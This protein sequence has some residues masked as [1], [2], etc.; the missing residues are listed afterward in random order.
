M[1]IK[2]GSCSFLLVD[3]LDGNIDDESSANND[4]LSRS[5][6]ER[7]MVVVVAVAG[8]LTAELLAPSDSLK[9]G[10]EILSFCWPSS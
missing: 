6:A 1:L 4:E 7:R 10:N 2:P 5:E 9:I 8:A 3:T